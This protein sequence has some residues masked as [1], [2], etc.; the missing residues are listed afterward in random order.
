MKRRSKVFVFA[1]LTAFSLSGC[2]LL[3]TLPV[4]ETSSSSSYSSN[5]NVDRFYTVIFDSDGG[6]YVAPQSIKEGQKITEPNQP[7]KN[8]CLFIG[9][10]YGDIYWDFSNRVYR[11]MTLVAQWMDDPSLSNTY[12]AKFYNEDTTLLWA[13]YDIPYGTAIEY[14]G[15]TPEKPE[16]HKVPG[17]KYTFAGWDKELVIY[18]NTEFYARYDVELDG[19]QYLNWVLE[20]TVPDDA[21][22][23]G[24]EIF[25]TTDGSDKRIIVINVLK[26]TLAEGSS[27]KSSTELADNGYMKLSSNGMSISYQF[28]LRGYTSGTIY[29][30]ACMDS[31]SS[32]QNRGDVDYYYTGSSSASNSG[33]FSINFNGELV[34]YSHMRGV[35]YAAMLSDGEKV[36]GSS[37][38]S[39]VNDCEVGS[40][41]L[42]DGTNNFTFTRL[43]SYGL[44]ISHFV[45][46]LDK[47]GTPVHQHQYDESIWRHNETAHWH[48]CVYG[49]NAKSSYGL[50]T[51]GDW[52]TIYAAACEDSTEQRVCTVCGYG[53]TRAK[54]MGNHYSNYL[55]DLEKEDGYAGLSVYECLNCYKQAYRWNAF[56]YDQELSNDVDVNSGFVR[57]ASGKAENSGGTAQRGSHIVYKINMPCAAS[58]VGLAFNIVPS[59]SGGGYPIFNTI[60]N[61]SVKGY[62]YDAQGNFVLSE[63]RYGLWVNG[64]KIQLGDDPYPSV[65][66]SAQKWYNWP[67]K[68][69]LK[70]GENTIDL[71]CYGSYRARMYEFQVIGVV[72]TNIHRHTLSNWQFDDDYHWKVCTGGGCPSAEGA[73]FLKEK[74]KY[75]TPIQNNEGNF[76]YTC[77]VCGK[78]RI[79]SGDALEQEWS[80]DDLIDACNNPSPTVVNYYDGYKGIKSN[81]LRNS[82]G[83]AITLTC[84]SNK[85]RLMKLQLFLSIKPSNISQTGFWRQNNN[86]KIRIIINDQVIEAPATDLDFAALGCTE[87]DPIARDNANLSIPVWIDICDF[88]L[89]VGENTIVLTMMSSDYSFFICGA[90]IIEY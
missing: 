49:D 89:V 53:E 44:Y 6:S 47:P 27:F 75:G 86:E 9:W 51:F 31:W 33:N 73:Q 59:N 14:G 90:K 2:N 35:P 1:I 50:H 56:D 28:N 72:N 22:N 52:T 24:Y 60:P 8:N 45:I 76:V 36:F 65:T 85:A 11:D 63:K 69:N 7:T 20:S 81:S 13:Q 68:F 26:G 17:Y 38:Y 30:R 15:P 43:A 77:T 66:D 5:D 12:Y 18:G 32:Y 37:Q 34:D 29:M 57:F 61:D 79:R 88:N 21:N 71:C 16:D 84:T 62:D 83:Y 19:P 42:N 25:K 3:P 55:V 58:N 39:P 40:V 41:F 4:G 70:Q 67:V 82:S 23:I 64:I 48:P 10:K 80:S 54:D 74:H 78:Q 87:Q 46:Y